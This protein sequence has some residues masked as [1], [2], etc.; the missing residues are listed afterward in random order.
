MKH[1]W[2]FLPVVFVFALFAS[3]AAAY[4]PTI[5]NLPDIYI[6]DKEDWWGTV[7]TNL[8]RFS[9][10]FNLDDYVDDADNADNEL[11]WSFVESTSNNWLKINGILQLD[12]LTEDPTDPGAKNIRAVSPMVSL[13]DLKDS[14]ESGGPIWP[15]PVEPLNEIVTF[16]VS[17]GL[18]V[19][20]DTVLVQAVDN[21]YDRISEIPTPEP[22]PTPGWESI[23]VDDFQGNTDG[24]TFQ[25]ISL[26]TY[27]ARCAAATST[28]D[29]NRVGITTDNTTSRFGWWTNPTLIPYEANK[30]Y[31]VAWKCSTNQATATAVPTIRFRINAGDYSYANE[32]IIT[33]QT[34]VM[35]PPTTGSRTYNQYLVPLTAQGFFLTFDVYDFDQVTDSGTVYLEEVETSKADIPT[36]GWSAKTVPA[37]TN[38]TLVNNI[39][40][41]AAFATTGQT[42][43][44]LRLGSPTATSTAYAYWYSPNISW[45]A[46][47]LNRAIFTLITASGPSTILGAV[48]AGSADYNWFTRYRFYGDTVPTA[49]G[50]QYPVYFETASGTNFYLMYEGMDFETTRGGSNDLNSVDLAERDLW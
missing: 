22:T 19:D 18:F 37:F 1:S 30:L 39:S 34:G 45:T 14:P 50:T 43:S 9:D 11:R 23:R 2:R 3:M 25:G 26:N 29:G 5:Q 31:K 41:Y 27:D 24:Y 47:K 36:A 44:L 12:L 8:F 16:Y 33:S 42:A 40:P 35:S 17:D 48:A 4:A 21:D 10:A 32:L 7:D 20:S 15:D 13:W 28:F 38:W 46:G 49:A 6:G